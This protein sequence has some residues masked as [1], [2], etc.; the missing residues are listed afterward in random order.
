MVKKKKVGTTQFVSHCLQ[1]VVASVAIASSVPLHHHP[2][3]SS[4][5]LHRHGRSCPR[6]LERDSYPHPKPSLAADSLR[7]DLLH[8]NSFL[9]PPLLSHRQLRPGVPP[10]HRRR[11]PQFPLVHPA[12]LQ[13]VQDPLTTH[14]PHSRVRGLR[15]PTPAPLRVHP[16]DLQD[17]V[18]SVPQERRQTHD[19][20]E[21]GRG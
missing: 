16:S 3:P 12:D 21:A 18:G 15:C 2:S 9:H 13:V 20:P 1:V 14:R 6:D 5:S 19:C 8:T 11:L 4:A 17:P 7:G 10:A